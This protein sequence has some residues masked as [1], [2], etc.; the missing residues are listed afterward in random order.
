M[1][2]VLSVAYL[3]PEARELG[4]GIRREPHPEEQSRAEQSRAE[5]SR[6][7]QSRAEQ[8]RA[9]QSRA[10]QSRAEQSRAEQSRA[11]AR[12]R[13]RYMNELKNTPC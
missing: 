3:G 6:A 10:E 5:Q 11:G 8:S 2:N 7:E 1:G 4:V 9:E 12:G 13:E